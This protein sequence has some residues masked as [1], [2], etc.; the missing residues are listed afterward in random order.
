M[1]YNESYLARR[2]AL[3]LI[4]G[5]M[6]VSSAYALPQGGAVVGGG[7]AG[8][9]PCFGLESAFEQAGQGWRLV[10]PFRRF[11]LDTGLRTHGEQ[12]QQGGSGRTGKSGS[13]HREVRQ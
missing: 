8:L 6:F 13:D 2:L 5:G 10:A 11:L 9:A 12:G 3:S 1:K 4:I 7:N